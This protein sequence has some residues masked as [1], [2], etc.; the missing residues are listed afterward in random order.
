MRA[1]RRIRGSLPCFL[2]S[3]ETLE[4]ESLVGA[5][6][7][8]GSTVIGMTPD[9]KEARDAAARLD[10]PWIVPGGEFGVGRRWQDGALREALDAGMRLALSSGYDVNRPGCAS[11]FALIALLRREGRLEIEEILQL[12]IANLAYAL[13]V[14]DRLGSLQAGHEANLSILECD[15]YREIGMHLGLPP[16]LAAFRRGALMERRLRMRG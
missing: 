3:P 11:P 5:S 7:G 1:L 10:V 13:G 12:T 4:A 14:G 9:R 16:I 15:D 8:S 6:S 2:T